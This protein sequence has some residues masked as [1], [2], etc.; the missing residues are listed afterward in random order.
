MGHELGPHA[1]HHLRKV[2]M[3]QKPRSI[4]FNMFDVMFAMGFPSICESV[5]K[6]HPLHKNQVT[7]IIG[8]LMS[9][10]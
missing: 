3:Q 6:S 10:V 2:G 9:G 1:L 7:M 8:L 4:K 5:I